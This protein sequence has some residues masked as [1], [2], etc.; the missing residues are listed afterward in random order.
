V[1]LG[2]WNPIGFQTPNHTGN[3]GDLAV[4]DGDEKL[5]RPDEQA[6]FQLYDLAADPYETNDLAAQ[7]PDRVTELTQWADDWQSSCE[8]SR[9]GA[10][11]TA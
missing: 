1:W 9:S 6:A 7:R 2:V 8:R 5:I 11:Y 3:G 4:I 10:D